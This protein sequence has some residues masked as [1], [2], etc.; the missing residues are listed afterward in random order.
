MT[1]DAAHALGW[2]MTSTY[3]VTIALAPQVPMTDLQVLSV[4]VGAGVIG[5]IGAA[6][7]S[8]DALTIRSVV[9]RM[10]ASGMASG[11]MVAG[12]IIHF[13]PEPRLLAVGGLAMT[14]GLIAWPVS[15]ALPKMA[16]ALLRDAIKK[17][18]G[19]GK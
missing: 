10:L 4:S 18:L 1:H 14:A 8:D 6:L 19:G 3:G 2:M 11:A 12:A 13:V 5:G 9:K 17:W 15:Q 7:L 16:P